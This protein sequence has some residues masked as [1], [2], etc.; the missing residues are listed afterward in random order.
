[1]KRVPRRLACARG[2]L[3]HQD[4]KDQGRTEVRGT[5]LQLC[6]RQEKK[7]A[8]PDYQKSKTSGASRSPGT[9]PGTR[10]E[11]RWELRLMDAACPSSYGMPP[12]SLEAEFLRAQSD[13]TRKLCFFEKAIPAPVRGR[14]KSEQQSPG[15]RCLD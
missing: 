2:R 10:R 15:E 12:I 6:R 8:R 13:A 14:E 9:S 7:H 3:R 5:Q 1:M 11:V 4:Q